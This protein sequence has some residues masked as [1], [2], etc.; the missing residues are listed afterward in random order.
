MLNVGSERRSCTFS[1]GND[2]AV[3]LSQY[4]IKVQAP[5]KNRL[6]QSLLVDQY[7]GDSQF[8]YTHLRTRAGTFSILCFCPSTDNGNLLRQYCNIDS[9]SDINILRE[10][11]SAHK[12]SN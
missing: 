4:L 10:C 3:T 8:E 5:L 9:Y 12:Y 7:E 11:F 2:Q 6:E 1:R